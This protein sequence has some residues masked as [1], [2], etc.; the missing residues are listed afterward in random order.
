LI[1][2]SSSTT[3]TPLSLASHTNLCHIAC[4]ATTLNFDN[5]P[6]SNRPAV[7]G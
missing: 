3:I 4:S 2:C 6:F 7:A 1:I 5:V